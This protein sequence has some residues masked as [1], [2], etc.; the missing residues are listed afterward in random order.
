MTITPTMVPRIKNTRKIR[1]KIKDLLPVGKMPRILDPAKRK[2]KLKPNTFD[3]E[4]LRYLSIT[5]HV[6]N[7]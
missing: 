6:Q 1:L 3:L 2:L 5:T 4:R 7:P